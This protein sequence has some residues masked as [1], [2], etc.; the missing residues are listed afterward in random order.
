MSML[1][2]AGLMAIGLLAIVGVIF[3]AMGEEKAAAT[4]APGPKQAPTTARPTAEAEKEPMAQQH[5]PVVR[6]DPQV[7]VIN[8]QFRELAAQLRVLHQQAR[9][10]EQRLSIL[11]QAADHIERSQ[12]PGISIEEAE[13]YSQPE[14]V[15]STI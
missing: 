2:I 13:D 3:L 4:T 1:I 14:P 12:I 6:E 9:E 5:L 15:S 8:G 7:A 11:S 10:I